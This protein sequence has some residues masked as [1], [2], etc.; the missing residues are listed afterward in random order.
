MRRVLHFGAIGLVLATCAGCNQQAKPREIVQG[1]VT[2]RGAALPGG[3]IV[4]TPDVE[5]G[6]DGPMATA[7]IKADGSYSLQTAGE[8]GAASGPYRVTIA[9]E[10]PVLPDR[11]KSPV[12]LPQMYSDAEKSGL[13]REVKAGE[14][15]IINFDLD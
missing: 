4:F 1:R 8:S 12:A 9:S 10:A 13:K 3:T 2:Y 14:A 7:E 6:G 15:N 5:R 11:T